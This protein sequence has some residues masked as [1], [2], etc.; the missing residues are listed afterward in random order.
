M[1]FRKKTA[2]VNL[3]LFLG[4]FLRPVWDH[5]RGLCRPHLRRPRRPPWPRQIGLNIIKLISFLTHGGTK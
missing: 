4:H 3:P 1:L 2:R 5:F